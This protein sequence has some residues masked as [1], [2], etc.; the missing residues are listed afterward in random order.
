[1]ID[2]SSQ[3]DSMP[4]QKPAPCSGCESQRL[5]PLACGSCGLLEDNQILPSPF[6]LFG[7]A[8]TW[9]IC[10]AELRK[11][12][13]RITRL[14][15]P[16]LHG[17]DGNEEQTR[18]AEHHTARLNIAYR[19][20]MDDVERT[21]WLIGYLNGPPASKGVPQ[22]LLMEVMDWNEALDEVESGDAEASALT[23]L[24]EELQARRHK[25]M[26]ELRQVLD[27]LPESGSPQLQTAR[28]HL[29]EL[30]YLTR[31]LERTKALQTA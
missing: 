20:L 13:L 6:Q 28:E 14:T 26:V 24:I 16:D 12:L 19:A 21:E 31:I 17:A 9:T 30:R 8:P 7:L 23:D 4:E 3:T 27:P 18:L 25:T 5:S 11:R 10:P 1:M 29:D 2:P 15:H 22:S